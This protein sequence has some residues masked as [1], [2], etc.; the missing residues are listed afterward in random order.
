MSKNEPILLLNM[1]IELSIILHFLR[2]QPTPPDL[3]KLKSSGV[4]VLNGLSVYLQW[5]TL[6]A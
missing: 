5:S 6:G 4:E 2:T 1:N 3:K